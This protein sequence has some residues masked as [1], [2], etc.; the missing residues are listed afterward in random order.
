MKDKLH[1]QWEIIEESNH[2]KLLR[3]F[4]FD[5]YMEAVN[6]LN[7]VVEIAEEID[8]HPD[9]LLKWASLDISTW[10]HSEKKIT[11]LD[12]ELATRIDTLAS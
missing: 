1:P 3:K 9:I 11:D 8:H 10:T 7:K 2:K 5:T 6:F 4:D 12:Y